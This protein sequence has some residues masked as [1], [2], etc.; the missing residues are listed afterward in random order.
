M[1][2][3]LLRIKID[4]QMFVCLENKCSRDKYLGNNDV[5]GQ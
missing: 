3:K 2:I 1:A 4:E 5:K